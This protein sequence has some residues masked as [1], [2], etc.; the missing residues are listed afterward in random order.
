MAN[1]AV[2][3]TFTNST[4][5]DA[6][7]VNQNFTDI[8][9]GTSDGTKDFSINALTCAGTATLNGNVNIGNASGDDLT[10][11]A[12]LASDLPI[13]TNTTY[14]I[15]A[16]TK[17]LLGAYFGGTSTF[18]AKVVAATHAASRVYTMPDAGADANFVLSQGTATIAGTKTFS[19]QLIGKGTATND[20]AAAG[21]IGETLTNSVQRASA[22]SLTTATAKS[23]VSLSLTAGDWHVYGGVGFKSG[24]STSVTLR[25]AALSL[26]DNTLPADTALMNP[27]TNEGK[28]VMESAAA[29]QS[30]NSDNCVFFPT[31][32]VSVST[33]TTFYLVARADFSVST[34]TG[35]GYIQARRIR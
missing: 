9:N 21:Y 14:S 16:A 5:A 26:T 29:V 11:T 24:G 2:T 22:T 3:N 28:T 12:S 23:I 10:I 1:V 31:T 6:T 30:N 15:G 34:L 18:T 4:T 27:N 33:T 8:I 7:Q 20:D 35:Y 17:G 32:R 19:G 25:G 13:K